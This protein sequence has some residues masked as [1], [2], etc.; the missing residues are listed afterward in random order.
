MESR[1]LALPLCQH[2]LDT[3]P[4]A[5]GAAPPTHPQLW[6]PARHSR[7]NWSRGGQH[8]SQ[9]AALSALDPEA[10]PVPSGSSAPQANSV[11]ASGC[12]H[13][14]TGLETSPRPGSSGPLFSEALQ[15]LEIR[16]K[17]IPSKLTFYFTRT[18]R[19]KG[20]ERPDPP[21]HSP[22]SSPRDSRTQK[23]M[24]A[25]YHGPTLGRWS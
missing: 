14:L 6:P 12:T 5:E 16:S 20:E 15:S 10:L 2:Q 22:L 24:C 9:R 8:L 17:H 19:G 4:S 11:S 3:H 25:S 7:N 1:S 21:P 18:V 13:I 23:W